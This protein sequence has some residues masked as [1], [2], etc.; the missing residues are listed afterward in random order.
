[1]QTFPLFVPKC[2][3]FAARSSAALSLARIRGARSS[4]CI[5]CNCR[6]QRESEKCVNIWPKQKHKKFTVLLKK[7]KQREDKFIRHSES[8]F[9]SFCSVVNNRIAPSGFQ[10]ASAPLPFSCRTKIPL[11]SRRR[12]DFST[13][14][15]A[16]SE[17]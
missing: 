15:T 7:A 14:A 8:V 13:R 17:N 12:T 16:A 3:S 9:Y 4:Q 10:G 5:S 1:M 6:D 2:T 11:R